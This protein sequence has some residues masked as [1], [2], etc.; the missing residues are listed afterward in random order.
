M[1]INVGELAY[2]LG[3]KVRHLLGP[4]AT[5]AQLLGRR[6]YGEQRPPSANTPPPSPPRE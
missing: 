1:A 2:A 3:R 5:R 6:G 4:T